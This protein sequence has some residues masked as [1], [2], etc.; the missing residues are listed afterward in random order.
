[1]SDGILFMFDYTLLCTKEGQHYSTV[2]AVLHEITYKKHYIV[3]R[4][5]IEG[6]QFVLHIC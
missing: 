5:D 2:Q 6:L 3:L 4:S 1:M